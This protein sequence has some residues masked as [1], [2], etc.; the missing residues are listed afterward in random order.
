MNGYGVGLISSKCQFEILHSPDTQHVGE[1]AQTWTPVKGCLAEKRATAAQCLS[2]KCP[3]P[4]IRPQTSPTSSKEKHPKPI[5]LSRESFI[6]FYLAPTKVNRA[7][8]QPPSC[9]NISG[10]PLQ[11]P[12]T[13]TPFPPV[14]LYPT[15]TPPS[16]NPNRNNVPALP[17]R[18]H[19]SPSLPLLLLL[20]RLI[21]AAA[22]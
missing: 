19:R 12:G 11:S 8:R 15:L 9:R 22:T 13:P 4:N 21:A 10:A 5:S 18:L 16:Q 20:R 14:N 17:P 3:T 7:E 1:V 6:F 2:L